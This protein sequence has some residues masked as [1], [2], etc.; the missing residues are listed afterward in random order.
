MFLM[1]EDDHG[2]VMVNIEHISI[3]KPVG[4]RET[5]TALTMIDGSRTFVNEPMYVLV[6]RIKTNTDYY[7]A[8]AE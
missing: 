8:E 1:T 7:V 2:T 5:S 6:E 4:G 3:M